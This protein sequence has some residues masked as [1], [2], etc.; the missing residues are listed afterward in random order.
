MEINLIIKMLDSHFFAVNNFN[1][2]MNNFGV[3][4]KS[5]F[6]DLF[7]LVKIDDKIFSVNF[8]K[9]SD[10]NLFEP[11]CCLNR[12]RLGLVDI[13]RVCVKVHPTA[14]KNSRVSSVVL[15]QVERPYLNKK[16]L[17]ERFFLFLCDIIDKTENF[18]P[19]IVV[20]I[21]KVKSGVIK[22]RRKLG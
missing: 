21:Q 6:L 1:I 8:I 7:S 2:G 18:A 22:Q 4:K 14:Y 5:G 11:V 15:E 3:V 9:L 20:I 12:I 16:L 19:Q 17:F 13:K 10:M